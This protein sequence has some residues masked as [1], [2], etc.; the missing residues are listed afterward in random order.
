M[1]CRRLFRFPQEM[2]T[3]D[4][5]M[6]PLL[7]IMGIP[8]HP[9][10]IQVDILPEEAPTPRGTLATPEIKINREQGSIQAAAGINSNSNTLLAVNFSHRAVN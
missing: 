2:V 5:S 7:V 6:G 3:R 8:R 10:G 4:N 9:R 1:R